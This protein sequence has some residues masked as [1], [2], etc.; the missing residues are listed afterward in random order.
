M[1]AGGKMKVLIKSN[2]NNI[3]NEVKGTFLNNRIVYIDNEV[4]VI[5]DLN[6]K[7]LIRENIDSSYKIE[8]DFFN[9]IYKVYI[10]GNTY[11]NI[12]LVLKAYEYKENKVKIIY[13]IEDSKYDYQIEYIKI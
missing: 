13:F 7:L 12:N 2:L 6:K 8:L 5:L 10:T 9:E 3:Q 11:V 1:I 4:K